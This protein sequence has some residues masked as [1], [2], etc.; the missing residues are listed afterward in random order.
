ELGIDRN[1]AKVGR[2]VA[3]DL[4]VGGCV[5]AH[6]RIGGA[7]DAVAAH[8]DI[9]GA[10]DVDGVAVLAGTTGGVIDILD[11]VVDDERAV[12]ALLRPVHE[13]AAVAGA[14]HDVVLDR[15]AARIQLLDGD[16]RSLGD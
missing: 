14:A 12:V 13:N 16:I 3:G 11:A 7:A 10:E 1:L 6:R 8:D 5:A 15:Q 4:D 9:A 2:G